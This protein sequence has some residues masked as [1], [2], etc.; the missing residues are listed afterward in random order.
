VKPL[1]SDLS[2]LNR[3]GFEYAPVGVKFL[4]KEPDGIEQLDKRLPFCQMMRE[5]QER[6]APF[7]FSKENEDCFGVMTLGMVDVPAFAEAGILGEEYGVFAEPRANQ[8]IYQEVMKIPRGVVNY[9][10]FAPLNAL[11]FEPDLML[12]LAGTSQAE[13]I[14]RAFSYSTGEVWESKK[15]SVLGC[16]WIYVYPYLTG[17]L[18]YMI[19]GMSFG[20]KAK[21][22][23]PEGLIL[24][25]IPWDKLSMIIDNLET[26]TWNLPSYEE[27]PEDFR[28]REA[29]LKEEA[30]G[31][32]DG[33]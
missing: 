26:M 20:S 31:G 32:L 16:A 1:K 3:F 33:I 8:R 23:F 25:S 24:I 12:L 17:K 6:G 27:G 21:R 29:R 19:T 30:F 11:D 5:A 15:T 9:V 18:N 28:K 4:F 13:I 14:M 7:Y 10:C 2:V 22:V